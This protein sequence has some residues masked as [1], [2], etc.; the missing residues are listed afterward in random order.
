MTRIETQSYLLCKPARSRALASTSCALGGVLT[1]TVVT[2]LRR[3]TWTACSHSVLSL[4]VIAHA[5]Y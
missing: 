1:E 3:R 2:L 4:A 5:P